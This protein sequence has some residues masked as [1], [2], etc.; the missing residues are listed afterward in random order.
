MKRPLSLM[1]LPAVLFLATGGTRPG[2]PPPAAH[3]PR[4]LLPPVFLAKPSP[5]ADSVFTTLSLNERIA[6]LPARLHKECARA[7]RRV[8]YLQLEDLV[9]GRPITELLEHRPQRCPHDRLGQRP[10]RVV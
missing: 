1:A 8:T 4:E 9:R 10:R 7:H 6:Q 5:W 3:G 2:G